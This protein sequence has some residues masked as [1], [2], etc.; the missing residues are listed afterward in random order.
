M[1]APPP[2]APAPGPAHVD[3]TIGARVE[4]PISP[5]EVLRPPAPTADAVLPDH[6][7]VG[8]ELLRCAVERPEVSAQAAPALS[9]APPPLSSVR[10]RGRNG[11][12]SGAQ[13]PSRPL[14]ARGRGTGQLGRGIMAA[15]G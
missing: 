3:N 11:G 12:R 4:A 1:G 9:L 6:A 13:G 10:G 5:A 15:R 8:K 2:E 14:A 7:D